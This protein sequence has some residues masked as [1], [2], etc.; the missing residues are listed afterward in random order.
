MKYP[1]PGPVLMEHD[2]VVCP[3]FEVSADTVLDRR[4]CP[5]LAFAVSLITL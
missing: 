1:R 4:Q 3:V 2:C 5:V